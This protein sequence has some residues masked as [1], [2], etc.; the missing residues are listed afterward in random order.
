MDTIQ[1]LNRIANYLFLEFCDHYKPER[2]LADNYETAMR[3]VEEIISENNTN[4]A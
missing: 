4:S 2:S 1:K 3:L